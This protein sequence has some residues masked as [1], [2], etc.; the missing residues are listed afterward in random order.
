MSA[1][2]AKA[3]ADVDRKTA[4]DAARTAALAEA[5]RK[6]AEVSLRLSSS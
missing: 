6:A 1:L 5:Q 2:A 4:A 3:K